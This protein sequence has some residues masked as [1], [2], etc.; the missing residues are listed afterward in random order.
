MHDPS[1]DLRENDN[2]S[3]QT[4][5][6]RLAPQTLRGGQNPHSLGPSFTPPGHA[7]ALWP[8]LAAK[9]ERDRAGERGAETELETEPG[10]KSRKQSPETRAGDKS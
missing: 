3:N 5:G 8:H 6:S 1:N 7:H 10:D 4:R 9:K 2:P